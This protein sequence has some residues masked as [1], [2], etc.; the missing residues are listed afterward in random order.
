MFTGKEGVTFWVRNLMSNNDIFSSFLVVSCVPV[1]A[2]SGLGQ[3]RNVHFY[4]SSPGWTVDTSAKMLIPDGRPVPAPAPGQLPAP[5]SPDQYLVRR[6]MPGCRPRTPTARCMITS[7]NWTPGPPEETR[8]CTQ[9]S[10]DWKSNNS[11][12]VL[13]VLCV[14]SR[15]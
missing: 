5:A 8:W 10:I 9:I 1:M 11:F 13:F 2:C 3:C 14:N 6:V 4:A 7:R 12:C 15:V